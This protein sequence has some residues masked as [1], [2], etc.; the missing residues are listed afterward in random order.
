MIKENMLIDTGN[1]TRINFEWTVTFIAIVV[2]RKW[3]NS[4][5]S[6]AE[7]SNI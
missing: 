6:L 4:K 1:N 2:Q 7:N 5:C 3:E